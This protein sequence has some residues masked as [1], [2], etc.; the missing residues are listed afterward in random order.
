[1]ADTNVAANLTVEQWE[2]SYYTE[3]VRANRFKRYM[4]T[5]ES[6]PIQLKEDLTKKEGETIHIGLLTKLSGPGVVGNATLEGSE[7]RLNNFE[8]S[9]SVDWLRNAVAVDKKEARKPKVDILQAAKPAL[10]DWSM[11]ALRDGI[12]DVLGSANVN[13]TTVYASCSEANKDAWLAANSDRVLFGAAKGNNASNDHSAALANV[14]SS[15]DTFSPAILMLARR[16]AVTASPAIRPIKVN[17]DEEYFV[18]F[19]GSLAFRDFKA[20][21]AYQAAAKDALERGENN[22]LFRA[23]DLLWENIVIREVPEIGVISGVGAST[24]DVQ[25]FYLC[26]AQALAVAWAQ[27]P[28]SIFDERDYGFVKGVGIEECRGIKKL[29]FNNKQHGMLTGYVAGVADT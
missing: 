19:T 11:E 16:M 10:R 18:C 25:P 8:D 27:R 15:S 23:G 7:E 1:M 13:G 3:Y 6:M 14:D 28:K 20:S 26:G 4:G 2:D 21:A 24:I 9:I 17:E 5:D 29:M 22:P 12:I